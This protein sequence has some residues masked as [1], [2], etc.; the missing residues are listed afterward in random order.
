MVMI[1]PC[2]LTP[3]RYAAAGPQLAVPPQR[4]PACNGPLTPW[5]SYWR[6]VRTEGLQEERLWIPRGWCA[7]CGRTHALLPS[8]LLVRRL[9]VVTVIGQALAQLSEGRG[10]R[11]VAQQWD[12]PH[13]TVRD[14]GRRLRTR[15][16]SLLPLLLGGAT[17]LDP[18]PVH[19]RTDGPPAVLEV[20]TVAWQR[21]RARLGQRLPERWEFWSLISGGLA[22]APHTSPPFPRRAT[23]GWIAASL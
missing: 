13:T 3:S 1:W 7:A 12:L 19:L 21:A 22:L 6:W 17:S 5:G 11:L 4:C 16:A 9:D 23:E 14:W 10:A 2:P 20:V 8:F 15:A 18:A